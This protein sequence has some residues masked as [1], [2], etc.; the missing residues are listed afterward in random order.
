MEDVANLH[1]KSQEVEADIQ[2]KSRLVRLSSRCS[3]VTSGA[4]LS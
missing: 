4:T 3:A 1:E 2:V